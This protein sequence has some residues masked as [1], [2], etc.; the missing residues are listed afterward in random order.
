MCNLT[1]IIETMS[2]E[3]LNIAYQE[4]VNVRRNSMNCIIDKRAS[5]ELE[6]L[7]DR[8]VAKRADAKK[9]IILGTVMY[10]P[11]RFNLTKDSDIF[12]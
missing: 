6:M 7:F 5:I 9:A 8:E 4:N 11:T 3:R 1:T 10:E 12:G 2:D